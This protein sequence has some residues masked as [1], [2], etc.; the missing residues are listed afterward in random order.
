MYI[1]ALSYRA[2]I[3]IAWY[4][5]RLAPAS[6]CRMVKSM[7]TMGSEIT[8]GVVLFT[9]GTPKLRW[10]IGTQIGHLHPVFWSGI[11][12]TVHI[13][14]QVLKLVWHKYTMCFHLPLWCQCGVLLDFIHTN[15]SNCMKFSIGQWRISRCFSSV[16]LNLFS[17]KA[18]FL[19]LH[20][21]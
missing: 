18:K 20:N 11:F 12:A 17:V 5:I 8:D 9:L 14:W 19:I 21:L 10:H 15:N 7:Q 3:F 6:S 4:T 2:H 1:S 13:K 16:L